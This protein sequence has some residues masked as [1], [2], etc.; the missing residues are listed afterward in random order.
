MAGESMIKQ[1]LEVVA[2]KHLKICNR[3]EGKIE[4]QDRDHGRDSCYMSNTVGENV[5][6]AVH[7][8]LY[9]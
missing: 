3:G 4:F 1:F 7:N 9:L 2:A 5:L 8:A 6:K